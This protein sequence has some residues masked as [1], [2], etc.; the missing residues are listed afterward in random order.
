MRESV[1]CVPLLQVD[2][3]TTEGGTTTSVTSSSRDNAGQQQ[4]QWPVDAVVLAAGVGTAQ[5][6]AQLGYKLPLLHKPAAIVLTSPLQPGLLQHMVVTDTVFI[7]Q[8]SAHG[9]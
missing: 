5:L 1:W 4:Q 8:V 7:L 3:I 9:L 6:C 2:C